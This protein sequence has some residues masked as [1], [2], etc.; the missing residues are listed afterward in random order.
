MALKVGELYAELTLRD[1]T[2][3]TKLNQAKTKTGVMTG[4]MA[5]AT[6]RLS[7]MWAALGAAIG[8]AATAGVA[9]AIHMADEW[10][11]TE[12]AFTTM[13]GSAE[14]AKV[15]MAEL[16]AFGSKTPFGMEQLVPAAQKMLAF[17]FAASDIIPTLT[18]VGDAAAGLKLGGDEIAN[19]VFTFG[20]M[21]AAG[22]ATA[23]ALTTELASRGIPAWKYLAE[24]LGTD[25]AGAMKQVELRTVDAD[26][27]IKAITRGMERDFGGL[28]GKQAETFGGLWST[29]VDG[30]KE[31]TRYLGDFFLPIAKSVVGFMA[32]V[33]D[34]FKQMLPPLKLLGQEIANVWQEIFKAIGDGLKQVYGSQG[35]KSAANDY[36]ASLMAIAKV[37]GAFIKTHGATIVAF[38]VWVSKLS[39]NATK[40]LVKMME[41]FYNLPIIRSIFKGY[42]EAFRI[43]RIQIMGYIL[44]LDL[45]AM[46][47]AKLINTPD[48]PNSPKAIT[49]QELNSVMELLE[50]RKALREEERQRA[51]QAIGF[52]NLQAVWEGAMV[53]GTRAG[54][55]AQ[56][57][58][59]GLGLQDIPAGPELRQLL[60]ES[61]R[62][63]DQN[64]E[65][66]RVVKDRLGSYL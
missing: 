45:A 55:V 51:L 35:F 23:D 7:T 40:G 39:L 33:F 61:K 8:A 56:A 46:K 57:P 15:L 22:V 47:A 48:S 4:A 37:F 30:V 17:G 62:Q 28:M 5:G 63:T 19:I 60:T 16:Q 3:N 11:Q 65:L 42:S 44:E 24:V 59:K 31:A 18:A 38:V 12:L 13:L 1:Q 58:S 32:P 54:L 6:A 27:A 49:E 26:T 50:A 14:K 53:A 21:K 43:A 20:K 52:T 34:V 29:F 25:V 9:A 36:I 66:L 2:F 64:A 10:E 41:W